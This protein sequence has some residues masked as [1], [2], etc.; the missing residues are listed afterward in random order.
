MITI[1]I[2]SGIY[3]ALNGMES[4]KYLETK[5]YSKLHFFEQKYEILI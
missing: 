3:I 1:S 4:V 5:A 2:Y